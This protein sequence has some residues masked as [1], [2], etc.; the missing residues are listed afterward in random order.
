MSRTIEVDFQ[1]GTQRFEHGE[2]LPP[3]LLP[4]EVGRQV[5]RLSAGSPNSTAPSADHFIVCCTVS[6]AQ[7]ER[8]Q[9]NPQEKENLCL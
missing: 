4:R 9:L 1:I 5:A 2:E 7:A 3:N 6:L 8:E